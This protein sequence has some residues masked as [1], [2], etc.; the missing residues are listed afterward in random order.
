MKPETKA[1]TSNDKPRKKKSEPKPTPASPE[2]LKELLT[3]FG[4]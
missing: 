3:R 1:A 4:K 2:K